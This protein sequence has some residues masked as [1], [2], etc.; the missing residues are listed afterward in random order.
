MTAS[1]FLIFLYLILP[2]YQLDSDTFLIYNED[3]KKCIDTRNSIIV[4]ARCNEKSNTQKFRWISKN[5]LINVGTSQCLAVS[6]IA[7]LS[8]VTLY[9]CDGSS[10]LQK[11]EC[12]NETL[13][14]IVGS[15]L[16]LNYGNRKEDVLLYKGA[17]VWSKWKIYLSPDDL[18]AKAYEEIYTLQGNAN[19]QPCVF[20]FKFE[21]KW[22]ADCTTAGRS[23]GKLWCSATV[24]YEK[25]K[26]Y[27]FCP[28]TSTAEN[29]WT[30]D[31]VTGVNYQI[32]AN[33]A[34][35]WYQARRSCQQQNA[36]LL[37]VTELHEQSFISGLTNSLTAV[38]WMGLNSLDFNAG[39][40]WEGGGPFRYLNW[41][42][43][44]PSTEPGINCVSLN[45]GKSGKWESRE[46]SQKLGY[47]CKK[48]NS[49][50]SYVPP[51]GVNDAITCPASWIPYNGYCYT[52][53]KETMMWKDAVLAC[54]KEEGDLA[55]LHNIEESS[56]IT[57]Q[58]EFGDTEF[59]WL[60]LNDLKTQLFFEWSDGSPVTYTTWQRGEP[61][62][63]TNKQEDC[64]ALSTKDGHWADKMCEK[65]FPYL[66]KRKPLP[67][68]HEQAPPVEQG[69]DKG[70]K[71]H[72]FY[73]YL[74][75]TSAGSFPEANNTCNSL[76]AYLMTVE[77]RFEQAYLTSLIGFR[78]EKYFWTGLSDLEER[79]TFKW[80]NRERVLYTH[81]NAD[82]PG[83]KQGC[84]AMRTG[85]KA[86]LWDVMNCEESAKYVC[87]KWAQGVTPPPLPTTTPEP[88]CP[89]NWKSSSRSCYKHYIM[90]TADKK[91]WFNAKT[92]CRA[93]GGDL[94]S[95]SDKE[96]EQTVWSMLLHDGIYRNVFWVGLI[97]SNT[98]EG[99]AWSDDSPFIYENWAYGEPNN[100]QGLELCGE[101]NTD[102]RLTWNDRHCDIPQDWI[103]E[104]KKGATL[105]PEPTKSPVPDFELTSD[106]W[107]IR[108]DRQYYVSKE[109]VPMD[110]ARE[111]CKR[112]F[113]DLVSI[114]SE[115][116]R[117]FLWRYILKTGKADGY[118]IGLR[119]AVDR[120]FMWMDGSP[121][122]FVA[123][124]SYEPNFANNDENC[125][126]MYRNLG[127][128]NDINC[129][130]PNPFICERKNSSINATA[131]PTAPSP[132]GNC[133]PDWLL[134]GKKCYR[135]FGNENE[136]VID[137]HAARTSCLSKGGNLVT[138]NDDLTQS[139]LI[140]NL[141]DAKADVWIGM[142]DVNSEHKF[143][144][145][146]QS[147]V[148]FTNWAKGHPSGSHIYA[149]DDD[150]DCVAMKRGSVLDAGAWTEE[151]CEL[152]KGYICQKA[153]DPEIPAV[154]T[155]PSQSNQ[156]KYGD[157]SYKFV[158]N[159]MKWD[160]ARRVCK[161][162]DSE[163][164][165]ILNEYTT[166]FLKLH[167]AK[168]EEPFWIGLTSSNKSSDMYH[169]IDNWKLRYTKWAAGEPKRKNSCVYV[170]I[171]GQ[172][173][174]S[175][176]E[177]TYSAICKQTN[178]IAPTEPPQ[179]PGKC[180]ETGGKPWL[181]FRGHCYLIE[182][183]YTRNWASASMECLRMDA[184]L[185]SVEDSIELDF[186][187]HHLE[188]LSDNV[189]SFWV[190][191]YRN[192]EEK[193]LWL[194]NTPL[195][196]VNWNTGEPS[197][198]SDENCVEMYAT[199]GTWNNIY[200]SSYR[201]YVC[202]RLKIPLPTAKAIEKP[203]PLKPEKSSH[204]ITGGVV[205]VVI[206]VIAGATI[207]VYYLYRR[208]QNKSPPD[209]S[210]NNSLYFD[211]NPAPSTHD[212]KILVENI[213]QNEN[214][215]S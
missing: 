86:G 206:L 153:Q 41:V 187:F 111:F 169:W 89:P 171:D 60:G 115:S 157:A 95:I 210:F 16:H 203:E 123:W 167:L 61:S 52:L 29:M 170:D 44:N 205:I 12:K 143:L 34:L 77:D 56:F 155:A 184:N 182:S 149:Y 212:T 190:G 87:K 67:V 135:I 121:I 128:W 129:G 193:W 202:K 83:R 134:F 23:D 160:E 103:C 4:T 152:N 2:S 181:A 188:L 92:F 211:D 43:G 14:G 141:I 113:G 198:G 214:A 22:Y 132:Q 96:E 144:W 55:S 10:D 174:T 75:S 204:G 70:W 189:K 136:E 166:S 18:C 161:N 20:P 27:G 5:Q 165:S 42:P 97:N 172:W 48:G 28:S 39:W 68:D 84:V 120:E 51:S 194:D 49:S 99:F 6:S 101:V 195:D 98:E 90:E 168:H 201:G 26:L 112:N 159:K 208:K 162:S 139:F 209:A 30:T 91:S 175:S 118:F 21:N 36:E 173:K 71:R 65:K 147:G 213:E 53:L 200:C 33:S 176:C 185:I 131:A 7:D 58:F 40:R 122:D 142:N 124:A 179:K 74:I 151:E 178:V 25:E 54:R 180:P 76:G 186:L 37:S 146:D 125:V 183:T 130:Y 59:V 66:C 31:S 78:P 102:H 1:I 17:G 196:F 63:L 191:L 88:T 145:T 64:V 85:R 47:I 57:S 156:Y 116:E 82:M 32:N 199:K 104:L 207:A 197:D 140:A 105:K 150:T 107:V 38:L 35:T 108:D 13:F 106:G 73:C 137:W 11:W 80:T 110:K 15:P 119:L 126:T 177:E 158:K 9:T 79:N 114:N 154:P 8:A 127:Y 215:I 100:Y 138:I 3:H 19:G 93:I 148:Y 46:C 50:A 69:C 192:V 72:G 24:E 109:E 133:Q 81:W 163:L 45:P 117:R 164:V 62:H 94:L